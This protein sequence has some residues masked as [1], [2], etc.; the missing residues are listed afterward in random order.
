M[1]IAAI[2]LFIS[3]II[4]VL[5]ITDIFRYDMTVNVCTFVKLEEKKY[6]ESFEIFSATNQYS[7]VCFQ[8]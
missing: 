7:V 8:G 6:L 4:L 1:P 3:I 2:K 5:P